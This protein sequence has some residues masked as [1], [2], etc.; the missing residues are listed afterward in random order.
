MKKVMLKQFY[1]LKKKHPDALLL[2]RCGD[3]YETY[4]EDA[5]DASKILGITLTHRNGEVTDKGKPLYMAG[6]PYHALDVYL[7]K[8]IRAGKRCAICDSLETSQKKEKTKITEQ[9]KPLKPKRKMEITSSLQIIE[10][11]RIVPSPRN[12]RKTFNEVEL[13]ELATN[14]KNQGLLQPITVRPVD[15]DDQLD[16]STGEIVSIPIRYEIVCGERRYRA[17]SKIA[18]EAGDEYATIACIV[19]ELTDDEAFDAMITEN[20]QRKDVDPIEEAFAFG[21]LLKN[22]STAE[23]IAAR[24]GKSTRFVQERIK[25]NTLIAP[26]K[27]L[28]TSG[29]LPI[30]GAFK[31][32]K[33]KENL[34]LS[35]F[36][37]I[38]NR[39]KDMDN[40]KIEIREI[41]NWIA[42]EFMRLDNAD[43]LEYD[44]DD[45][46]IPPTEDWNTKFEKCANCCMNTG[47]T[48]CLFY[49]MKEDHRCTDRECFNNKSAGYALYE[50]E[51]F[52]DRLTMEGNVP[53]I[54]N[55]V[56]VDDVDKG[57]GYE[58]VK[59][60]R[61]LL[62]E[63]I[64]ERGYMIA[65]PDMFDGICKYYGD[66]E[67]IPKLLEENKVIECIQL[68]T[69]WAIEVETVYYYT[70]GAMKEDVPEE[71]PIEK[72]ARELSCKY[73]DALDKMNAKAN[74]ELKS[75][76]K[77][78]Q[79]QLRKGSL[80]DIEQYS[81]WAL[82]L[83]ETGGDLLR[84][85]IGCTEF[86]DQEKILAYVKNNF[87]DD[88]TTMWMRAYINKVIAERA[89][90]NKLAQRVMRGCFK[91]AYPKDFDE[92]T[93][94]H[95]D[96]FEKRTE[97]I[98]SRL[99][100]LGYNIEGKK[101]D[102]ES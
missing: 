19:K 99:D 14:I 6:F 38:K 74:E 66:D 21:E 82:I 39:F 73:R 9:V 78:K 48:N 92:L 22:G 16:E 49:S 58:N 18:E 71:D 57:Y 42:R 40:I 43:F 1:E 31:L 12:P 17:V 26:L 89:T 34:Q 65:T 53:Q 55:V 80:E 27:E 3:F 98:K 72:E 35:Y 96:K 93:R 90:Y 24:F 5:E 28:T 69:P 95:A 54:G 67:R 84:K 32:A 76:T 77:E 61:E 2:F 15:F 37:N 97:K 29:N 81:F 30:A 83:M 102:G 100:E 20:L 4:L 46:T 94:K 7:P 44:D 88:H 59:R 33:L 36:E 86:Y 50:I 56:I 79:Y 101:I 8:L 85:E 25:L 13:S 23:D 47:N 60:I 64:K 63:S 62:I 52:K 41:D 75:W 11:G 51:Q 10:I 68:G 87:T 91:L 70:K 45:E